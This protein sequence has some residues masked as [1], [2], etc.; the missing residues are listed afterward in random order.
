M[1]AL[2]IIALTIILLFI[3][4]RYYLPYIIISEAKRRAKKKG[5][6]KKKEKV[7][8]FYDWYEEFKNRG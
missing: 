5:T 3:G 7:Q 6:Y 2:I 1:K 8:N 4:M